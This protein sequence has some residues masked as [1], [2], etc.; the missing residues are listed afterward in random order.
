MIIEGGSGVTC[1][2]YGTLSNYGDVASVC[3]YI[4]TFHNLY[5]R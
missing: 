5:G 2:Y 3:V 4:Y 1:G